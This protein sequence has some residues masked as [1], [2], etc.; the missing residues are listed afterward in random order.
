MAEAVIGSV[1][2]KGTWYKFRS[3][4]NANLINI[5]AGALFTLLAIFLI[6]P[7]ISVLVKSL[8]V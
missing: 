6:Y 1:P 8:L 2:G 4:L 7:I 5:F 3:F